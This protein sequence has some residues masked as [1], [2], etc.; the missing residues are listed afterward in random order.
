MAAEILNKY[1]MARENFE[2]LFF[3]LLL[4]H[5]H[6]VYCPSLDVSSKARAE[7]LRSGELNM[8]TIYNRRLNDNNQPVRKRKVEV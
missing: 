5:S 4:A 3:V 7:G 1:R 8:K 6:S 2:Q